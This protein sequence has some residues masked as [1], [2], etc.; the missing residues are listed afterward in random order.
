MDDNEKKIF[1]KL[2]AIL[3]KTGKDEKHRGYHILP[4]RLN[5]IITSEELKNKYVFYEKERLAYMRSKVD[6]Q[7]KTIL[8]VGCNTGYLLFDLLDSGAKEVTGYEGKPLCG[9]FIIK[10]IDL[11]NEEDRFHFHNRYF[12]FSELND[13]Y[14]VIILLNV[15]HHLGDDYGDKT[16]SMDRAKRIIIEQINSM[17]KHASILIYQMGFN[18]HGNIKTCLFEHGLKAEMI[19]YLKNGVKNHWKII[20][21]GIPERCKSGI[22]YKDLD[23]KNIVRDDSLGEF[24]NRPIF[25]LN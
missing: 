6:F 3:M 16:L 1:S 24:L 9:E 8:D 5:S 10:A 12:N 17:R 25:I 23:D 13:E 19:N 11:F 20:A 4:E 7:N 2:N 14:D 21:I 18:W 22:I 15:L